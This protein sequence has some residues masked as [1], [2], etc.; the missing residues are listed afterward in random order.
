MTGRPTCSS[1]AGRARDRT[2]RA[3][4]G[5]ARTLGALCLLPPLVAASLTAQAPPPPNGSGTLVTVAPGAQYAKGALYRAFMGAGYRDLWTTPIT[6]PV[7][8][9]S[10][11]GGGLTAVRVGGGMT[12][13]TLHLDGADGRRYVLRSVDKEPADLLEDFVGTPIESILRDQISSF[14]PSGALV[15]ADLLDALGILHPRPRLVVVPDDPRLGEFRVEFAGMLALF[16]ERPDDAPDGAPG[17]AGSRDIVQT[18]DLFEILEDEPESH[19]A[20]RELLRSR[21]VD[22]L[23][24]DRDR[25]TNNHL[26][27]RFADPAGGVVWRV[28]PRD[29]DQ[30][31]VRFD[32]ILKGLAR[33]HDR[34]LVDFGDEYPSVF[35]LTRNAWDI[36]RT[37]LVGISRAEWDATVEEVRTTITD[38]VIDRAVRQLPPEHFAIL[39]ADLSAALKQRRDDLAEAAAELYRIVFSYADVHLTD[40]QE[41][42]TVERLQDGSVRVVAGPV[43][44]A[45][46]VTFDRTFSSGETAE[47]RLYMHGGSDVVTVRG[48]G[49]AIALRVMGGGGADRFVDS[50]STAPRMNL[51]Y[52]GGAA[53]EVV[54][55]PGTSFQPRGA[56]RLYSWLNDLRDLDWGFEWSPQPTGGYD[57]DRGLVLGGGLTVRQ[58]G[59]LKSPYA[60]LM[61]LQIGWS[62]GLAEPLVDYRHN[63]RDI[64]LGQDLEVHARVS[65]MEIIDFYGLGNETAEAGPVRFHRLPHKQIVLSTKVDF[66]DGERRRLGVGP[67]LRYMFTDSTDTSHFLGTVDPY[68]S[69]RFG[70]L[71]LLATAEL[72]GRD[73]MGTPSRGYLVEGGAAYYPELLDVRRGAFG[74]AHAQ[75]VAYLSPPGGNPT[76]ALRAQGRKLWGTFPFAESAFLGGTSS[77]RGI[78]EQR[79]AGDASVLGSAEVRLFLKRIVFIIPSDFGVMALTDAGRVFLDGESSDTWRASYGGGVWFA[80]LSRGA[81]LQVA[82]VRSGNRTSV[83]AG[84]G[85]PF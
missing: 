82:G 64:V 85:F 36:D 56:P 51:F 72:D 80:P 40:E 13:R 28:V 61:R 53:T 55:G 11:L 58:Y 73:R 25:S 22:L 76:L 9:L 78:R 59:F 4:S 21:L 43:D 65:G 68:G 60:D 26:W 8:D 2:K 7:A 62:F 41:E 16:E 49:R 38:D 47:V 37:F 42:A 31:F 35:G 77:L 50:S 84:L 45:L 54:S 74:E 46:G 71:G 66:G 32:G 3:S 1:P 52:D 12:T 34:R 30:A 75:A 67:V 39:G 79:Y 83:I 6:V 18:E 48:S 27:A 57:A 29:R 44:L 69:G 5:L 33:H 10:T 23:V 17:F 70:Q 19:V 15:V 20:A 81:V 24:G 14:N 63:F